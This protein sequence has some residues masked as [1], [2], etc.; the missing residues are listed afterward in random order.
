LVEIANDGIEA[1]AAVKASSYD[2][3]LMDIEMPRMNGFNAAHRIREL[4]GAAGQTPIVALTAVAIPKHLRAFREAGMDGYVAKPFQQQELLF[5]ALDSRRLRLDGPGQGCHRPTR[6][7]LIR[8]GDRI[9]LL[10]NVILASGPWAS[11]YKGKSSVDPEDW[12]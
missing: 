12:K 5:A 6:N 4:P 7:R 11:L 2:L 1:V 3:V 10:R 9:R 8:I